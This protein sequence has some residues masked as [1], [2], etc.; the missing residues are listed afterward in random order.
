MDRRLT[1]FKALKP[2]LSPYARGARVQSNF[3]GRYELVGRKPAV[4][5][6]RAKPHMHFAGLIVQGSYVGFYFMPIY[7]HRRAFRLSPR[8]AKLLKGK[9]CF[10]V[11]EV[12]AGLRRELAALLKRGAALYRRLGWL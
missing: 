1:T 2:L 10:H 3:A 9:S 8:L 5:A 7:S 12:D 11:K 4:V 6:G